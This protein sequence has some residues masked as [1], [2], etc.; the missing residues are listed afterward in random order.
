MMLKIGDFSRLAQVSIK[1]L[2][3]YDEASLLKPAEVDHFT[4]YR[5]YSLDQLSRLNQILVLRDLSFSLEQIAQI[6]DDG[7]S[8]DEIRGML[9]LKQME[10]QQQMEAGKARLVRLEIH[11]RQIESEDKMPDYD[12]VIKKVEPQRVLCIRQILPT[13]AERSQRLDE[14]GMALRKHQIRKAGAWIILYH[15]A[16]YRDRDLDIEVAIPVDEAVIDPLILPGARQMTIRTIP[17]VETAVS[18][19]LHGSYD[20]L[21]DVYRTLNLFIHTNG[22]NYLGPAREVYLRGQDEGD[23][24]T[25]YLTE[26]Q[27]PIGE[28][29]ERT[30][31]DG[32]EIPADW[33]NDHSAEAPYLPLSRRARTTLE[34]AKLEAVAL[35]Q[36]ETSPAHLLIALLRES[37]SLAAHVLGDLDITIEQLR[38]LSSRGQSESPEAL[39]TES[40]RQV[41]A[42]ANAEAIQF[43]HNY[44]GTEHLLLGIVRQRDASVV[45]L[46]G[47]GGVSVDQVQ[48][49]VLQALNP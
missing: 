9:R 2:R 34:L 41:T 32:V 12:I 27:Y 42:Y 4:G 20:Q 43:G 22:Y 48:A 39:V 29:A 33:G 6:L 24:P 26:I 36:S 19:L 5:Y 45:H 18:A 7:L 13:L 23:D 3:Y 15:H 47:A 35:Q 44:V 38:S 8:R 21:G 16:G 46:L 10:L 11:L 14:I 1:T 31:I 30:P 40:I 37:E 28:F 25:E 49:A 17:T